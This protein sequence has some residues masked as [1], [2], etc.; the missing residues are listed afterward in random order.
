MSPLLLAALTLILLG[1]ASGSA[2]AQ[3]Q[4]GMMPQVHAF[5]PSL[6]LA[7]PTTSPLQE[8]ERDD[9]ATTLR[10]QQR[11][12]LQRNPSALGRQELAIGHE[13]NSYTPR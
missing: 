7:A 9:Y 12:L 4:R 13:L 8:Q 10:A 11:D 3:E 2:S 6:S 5:N 1:F